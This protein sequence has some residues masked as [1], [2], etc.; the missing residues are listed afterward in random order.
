MALPKL[1]KQEAGVLIDKLCPECG[2]IDHAPSCNVALMQ[3][4]D[5]AK[6]CQDNCAEPHD[7]LT[8]IWPDGKLLKMCPEHRLWCIEILNTLGVKPVVLIG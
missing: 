3:A 6:C 4:A 2:R 5:E 1:T 7:N 8:V